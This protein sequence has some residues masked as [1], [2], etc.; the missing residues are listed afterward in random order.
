VNKWHCLDEALR[1]ESYVLFYLWLHC[2]RIIETEHAVRVVDEDRK[3]SQKIPSPGFREYAGRRPADVRGLNYSVAVCHRMRNR[4][5]RVK[6]RKRSTCALLRRVLGD[7]T[8]ERLHRH[9]THNWVSPSLRC[10]GNGRRFNP[11]G[12]GRSASFAN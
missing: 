12:N 1:P 3:M 7:D 10:A 5:E 9:R 2:L 6:L 11:T 4:F 8:H